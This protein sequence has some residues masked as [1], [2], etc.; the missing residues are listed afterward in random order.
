M[1][2]QTGVIKPPKAPNSKLSTSDKYEVERQMYNKQV[3]CTQDFLQGKQKS[4][5]LRWIRTHDTLQS[6]RKLCHLSY[7]CQ[8]AGNIKSEFPVFFVGFRVAVHRYRGR[9]ENPA[10]W[11][12]RW[13][14]FARQLKTTRH[15]SMDPRFKKNHKKILVNLLLKE[16]IPKELLHMR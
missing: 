6:R 15:I 10:L 2:E 4:C 1:W 11:T 3:N 12:A 8:S 13:T 9:W 5:L 7:Q 14:Y 16:K